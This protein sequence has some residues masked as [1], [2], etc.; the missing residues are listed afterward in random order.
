[1]PSTDMPHTATPSTVEP[2]SPSPTP[3]PAAATTGRLLQVDGLRAIAALAVV[4]YHY[5]TRYQEVFPDAAALPAALRWGNRGVNLFFAIS[6]F[7]IVMTLQRSRSAS[8]FSAS[9]FARLYPAYWGAIA[10]TT[11]AMLWLPLPN[12][13]LSVGQVLANLTML[14]R[15]F[16]V[17]DVDG[18]YWSLQIE[19]IFYA[20]MLALWALGA[21]R[22]IVP[23]CLAWTAA[24]LVARIAESHGSALP[25]AWSDALMLYWFPWFAI[26]ILTFDG[27]AARAAD[28][29]R[30][31]ALVLAIFTAGYGEGLA[32]ALVAPATA[33]L[34]HLA[35]RQQLRP[36]Q[37]PPLVFFG[38][39]SYPLYLLHQHIGWTIVQHLG[40]STTAAR[41]LGTTVAFLT[42]VVLAWGLHRWI[43]DPWRLRLRDWARRLAPALATAR[44]A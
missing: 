43:E 36:L 16:G 3:A 22:R 14:H 39:I 9:R 29:T 23:L 19:L 26:G 4:A 40:D 41:T 7:V 15:F 2:P 18:A 1:M 21:L 38:V 8:Q 27:R 42:S 30:L 31:A 34:L 35:A 25:V 33:A 32:T 44:R 17:H 10:L 24:S 11:V 28:P 6:G 12:E 37:W 5:T 20:W 13:S